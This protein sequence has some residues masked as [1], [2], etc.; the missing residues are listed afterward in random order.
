MLISGGH[1]LLILATSPTRF[2]ILAGNNID[3]SI[4]RAFDKTAKLLGV[5]WGERGPGA[6][7]EAYCHEEDTGD[8]LPGSFPRPAFTVPMPGRL[9]LS[10][11][12]LYSQV[13][14]AVKARGGILRDAERK[15]LARAFQH[16]AI[17][18]LEEKLL[19]AL[20]W[21]RRKEMNV[22][23]VVVSGGVASNAVL[24]ARSCTIFACRTLR[25]TK[26]RTGSLMQFQSHEQT[27][28]SSCI[29]HHHFARVRLD[30]AEFL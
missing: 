21:C 23:H 24:R 22:R 11:A 7:L 9:H 8:G 13:D 30:G 25:H 10:Y 3:L 1:T 28:Q 29:R 12:G 16:A 15:T 14:L 5:P 17:A 2:Q 20:N 19:L 6:A 18:Q 4:G 27:K 26:R